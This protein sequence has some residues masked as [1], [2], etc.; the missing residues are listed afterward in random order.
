MTEPIKVSYSTF[1]SVATVT[2]SVYWILLETGTNYLAF[3]FFKNNVY[4][5]HVSDADR[6]DFESNVKVTQNGVTTFEDAIALA[7]KPNS[8]G[9]EEDVDVSDRSSRLLGH[10]AVDA[11]SLPTGAATEATLALIKAKTDNLDAD[12]STLATQT[13]L[14]SVLAKLDVALSTR[15]AEATFTARI[16]TLGQ[17]AMTVSTPVVIASDQSSIAVTATISGTADVSDRVGRLLG[18]VTVDSSALPTGA[19]TEATVAT[20]ATQATLALIKTKTDN[21]DV[22]LST[23]ATQTTLA[24]VLAKLDVA[25]STRVAEATFTARIGTLGQKAMAGSTPVVIASDQSSIAVTATVSGTVDVGDRAGRLLGHVTVDSSAL[26][27]GAATETTLGTLATQ[28][29]LALIKAKTDNLDVL[30]SGRAA[31]HATAGS[32]HSVRL[33]DGSAFYDGT[34]TGQLPSALVGGRLDTN[35]GAWLGSTAPSVGQKASASSIPVV[36]ASDQSSIAVTATVSGTVDVSDRA[37]RLVGHVTVD[38]SALPTGAAT[39][40]TLGSVKTDLDNI[41]THQTDGTQKSISIPQHSTTGT[42]AGVIVST[43]AVLVK[44]ANPAR[45]S[46]A[47]TNSGSTNIYIGST[48]AVT[49]S[50]P[51]LGALLAPKGT[52]TDSGVGVYD[53]DIYAIGDAI[54][55]VQNLSVWERT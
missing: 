8:A 4:M 33:T 37:A 50:G 27:T 7:S 12:L 36:L 21:L 6:S 9:S 22:L 5:T 49:A 13:T 24:S 35:N 47:I 28:A 46:I 20:L 30:L 44:A 1:R 53:G 43:S 3:Y 54:S 19:A 11:S 52:Y 25:L 10:V 29:T 48:N 34:K 26:P 45:K 55:L 18:H 40:A 14:A 39:E 31:E 17:K 23:V 2:G 16:G 15:V 42:P 38:S 41:A 51:A 32:P